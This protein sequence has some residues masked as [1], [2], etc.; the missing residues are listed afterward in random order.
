MEVPIKKQ[1]VTEMYDKK[2]EQFQG[3]YKGLYPVVDEHEE[4]LKLLGFEKVV[5]EDY[6]YERDDR[7]IPGRY[8]HPATGRAF[9]FSRCRLQDIIPFVFY[10]GVTKGRM[11]IQDKFKELMGLKEVK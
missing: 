10:V 6:E 4:L 8:Y 3:E 5:D 7:M 9:D 2:T 1:G 11:E